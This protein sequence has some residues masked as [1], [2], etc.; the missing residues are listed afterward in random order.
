MNKDQLVHEYQKLVKTLDE[1]PHHVVLSAGGA[2]VM[3]GIRS[4][5]DDMDVDVNPNVFRLE[6]KRHPYIAEENV[7]PR[8]VY[9]E[10]IDLHELSENT[11]VVCIEGVWVYSPSEMLYQKRHLASIPNRAPGKRERDLIEI[12]QLEELARSRRLTSRMA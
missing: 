3:M 9:N 1:H 6:S 12:G 2:L 10:F 11:G 4:E 5:T 7:N 8:V